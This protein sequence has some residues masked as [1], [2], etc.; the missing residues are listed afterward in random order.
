MTAHSTAAPGSPYLNLT[1]FTFAITGSVPGAPASAIPHA[2][3]E[4]HYI[5]IGFARS[6]TF[7][8]PLAFPTVGF[9]PLIINTISISG[10][11]EF[12]PDEQLPH[13]ACSWRDLYRK[14]HVVAATTAGTF[15]GTLNIDSNVP[16]ASVSLT[17]IDGGR[18]FFP[19]RFS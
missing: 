12:Y 13:H 8:L 7:P 9:G 18:R 4:F 16:E 3:V 14:P 5:R 1:A 19:I 11:L 17:G 2:L 15:T 6:T 10:D